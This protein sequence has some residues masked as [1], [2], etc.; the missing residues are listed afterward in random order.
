[1]GEAAMATGAYSGAPWAAGRCV[2]V[3]VGGVSSCRPRFDRLWFYGPLQAFIHQASKKHT[4]PPLLPPSTP[5]GTHHKRGHVVRSGVR[6]GGET[7]MLLL[8]MLV[9]LDLLL[10][11]RR[12][13]GPPLP[14]AVQ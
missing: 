8:L 11:H 12:R 3:D 5:H 10:E 6:V 14:V 13:V 9:V 2:F 4:P 1:V 7:G